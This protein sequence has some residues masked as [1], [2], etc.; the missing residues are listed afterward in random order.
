MFIKPEIPVRQDLVDSIKARNE[1]ILNLH[2]AGKSVAAIANEIKLSIAEVK[3]ILRHAHHMPLINGDAETLMDVSTEV[4]EAI[5]IVRTEDTK[6]ELR[7]I[8]NTARRK[9]I[10]QFRQYTP[11][12]RLNEVIALSYNED[13]NP[14]FTKWISSHEPV[15][16]YIKAILKRFATEDQIEQAQKLAICMRKAK[17]ISTQMVTVEHAIPFVNEPTYQF[18]VGD[19]VICGHL[20][21]AVVNEKLWDGKAYIIEY[22]TGKDVRKKYHLD[23]WTECRPLPTSDEVPIFSRTDGLINLIFANRTIESIIFD[24][25]NFGIDLD[26]PYQRGY[27]W[28]DDDRQKLIRSIFEGAE[29]GRFVVVDKNT[30]S[31]HP[32]EYA[33]EILDGKQRL[34]TIIDFYENRFP[35]CG[36]YFNDLSGTDKHTFRN[37]IIQVAKV[38]MMKYSAEKLSELFVLLNRSGRAMTDQD[39]EK[40]IALRSKKKGASE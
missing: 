19:P 34:K 27:I 23:L 33:F 9:I 28:D 26:P 25:Y 21:N 17:E 3:A 6:E 24:V 11:T 15:R 39:I 20:K 16:R 31:A 2:T 32:G 36:L 5:R 12:M 18:E 14:E 29:I 30:Y 4:A 37:T 7:S 22:E 8:E 10:R 13:T 35:Y 1:Q 38:S 40:A